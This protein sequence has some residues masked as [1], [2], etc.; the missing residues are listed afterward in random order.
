MFRSARLHATKLQDAP[1]KKG[2]PTEFACYSKT[3]LASLQ[4]YTGMTRKAR[5]RRRTASTRSSAR[6]KIRL[7]GYKCTKASTRVFSI[8]P[9]CAVRYVRRLVN[10]M[11]LKYAVREPCVR[12]LGVHSRGE[13]GCLEKHVV[14]IM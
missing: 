13:C 14:V 1:F 2:Q 3:L 4:S 11:S 8:G 6:R 12:C 9:L 10:L 7:A 5:T